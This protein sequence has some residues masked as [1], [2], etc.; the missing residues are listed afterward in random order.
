[1]FNASMKFDLGEDVLA[2]Q[3]HVHRWAQD[4]I[5]PMAE[6]IDRENNFPEVLWKEMGDMGLHGITVAE[7]YGGLG[8]GY[9]AHT[10]VIEEIARA[11]ASVSLSY[12]AHSNLCINQL[13]LNG[14]EEQKEKYLPKLIS[15]LLYTSDAADD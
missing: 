9:L 15:C 1:M 6:D 8:L 3:E 5:R 14:S 4:R 2:F 11:S 7:K 13:H 12:G 10:V